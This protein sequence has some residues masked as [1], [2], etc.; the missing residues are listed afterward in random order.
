MESKAEI[1]KLNHQLKSGL[2]D[3]E[4]IALGEA[5][6]SKVDFVSGNCNSSVEQYSIKVA[7]NL[8]INFLF[9]HGS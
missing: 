5:L 7:T 3:G 1:I 9:N 4:F 8:T 6:G 2:T